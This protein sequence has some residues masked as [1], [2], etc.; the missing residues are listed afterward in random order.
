LFQESCGTAPNPRLEPAEQL[1]ELPDSQKSGGI[2][3]GQK[4]EIFSLETDSFAIYTRQ[5]FGTSEEPPMCLQKNKTKQN[6]KQR[7]EEEENAF[8]FWSHVLRA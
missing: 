5:D 8:C 1:Q 3:G 7:S 2:S 4:G 6:K